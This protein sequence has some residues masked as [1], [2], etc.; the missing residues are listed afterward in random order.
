MIEQLS[1]S[2]LDGLGADVWTMSPPCQ[3]FTTCWGA[4]QLGEE[5]ARSKAFSNLM[6]VLPRLQR[7]PRWIFFEN[8]KPFGGSA[9]HTAWCDTL[10]R[11]GYTL[12]LIHI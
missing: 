10:R 7:P 3:P 5:D 2:Y 8:V 11:A 9:V 4:K 12:S 1:A 6:H